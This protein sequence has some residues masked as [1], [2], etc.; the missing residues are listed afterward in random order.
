MRIFGL[1]ILTD[2]KLQEFKTDFLVD[3]INDCSNK[4]G[5]IRVI[6]ENNQVYF[7]N[8]DNISVMI[9]NKNKELYKGL[10]RKDLEKKKKR[11]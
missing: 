6:K 10:R 2:K 8:T 9:D 4:K 3:L 1:N 11:K 7:L 5:I